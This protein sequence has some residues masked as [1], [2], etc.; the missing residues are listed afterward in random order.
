MRRI[1]RKW[2]WSVWLVDTSRDGNH[3][4]QCGLIPRTKAQ[5]GICRSGCIINTMTSKFGCN[6]LK[7]KLPILFHFT[8]HFLAAF[9]GCGVDFKP[10]NKSSTS[11]SVQ[12]I[13]DFILSKS[14]HH[15]S[16]NFI[17]R[18]IVRLQKL[19][20]NL[21][22]CHVTLLTRDAIS[23]PECRESQGGIRQNTSNVYS[24]RNPHTL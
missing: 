16:L 3:V 1:L 2:R 10:P 12:F 24:R 23:G 8:Y 13:P 5:A 22:E 6:M 18:N 4:H 20:S 15:H 9:L 17:V 14:S 7:C 11:S 19:S 21:S